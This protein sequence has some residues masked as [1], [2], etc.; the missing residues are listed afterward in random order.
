M[1]SKIAHLE[2]IQGVIN[3]MAGNSFLIKGWS[4]TM[5][6]ALFALAAAGSNPL[7]AYLAYFPALAFWA[8]DAYFLRQERLFRKLYHHVRALPETAIDFSMNTS[9]FEDQ[10]NPTILV[11]FSKTL[12]LFHGTVVAT[13]VIIMFVLIRTR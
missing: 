13:I 9:P 2:M 3:R 10:V 4:V 12:R 5:V 7:F 11:A 1:E 8:L 6:S